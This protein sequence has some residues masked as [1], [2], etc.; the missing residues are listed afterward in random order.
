MALE[1]K[2]QQVTRENRTWT[3][4]RPA[5]G[6]IARIARRIA[7]ATDNGTG[8]PS[9]A[10][11]DLDGVG[12]EMEAVL[13]EYLTDAPTDWHAKT[14]D[15]KPAKTAE[16]RQRYDFDKVDAAE[17]A[18]VGEEALKFHATFRAVDGRFRAGG[19]QPPQ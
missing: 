17:F 15:G 11:A 10:V 1:P 8:V 9:L 16:G 18:E 3:L 6:G 2:T 14:S 4:T 13:A 12:I 5:R 19:S 7:Q